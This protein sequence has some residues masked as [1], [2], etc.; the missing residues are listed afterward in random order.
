M[1][2]KISI[3]L[4]IALVLSF[5]LSNTS[6]AA[7]TVLSS[8]GLSV[9]G[10]TVN[11]EKYNVDGSNYF[12]LRDIAYLLNGTK[13][14]FAVGWDASSQT[15]SILTGE[16]YT[17]NGTELDLSGGDKSAT[18][19]PSRQTIRIDGKD[20]SGLSVYNIGGNNYF[21]LRDLGDALGFTIGYDADT[22]TATISS[23]ENKISMTAQEEAH[24]LLR[25]WINANANGRESIVG[26]STYEKSFSLDNGEKATIQLYVDD[27]TNAIRAAYYY[28]FSDGSGDVCELILLPNFTKSVV[29]YVYI[30][31]KNQNDTDTGNGIIDNTTFKKTDIISLDEFGEKFISKNN[32]GKM[33]A[34]SV[35]CILELLDGIFKQDALYFK[36]Y[37]IS[38]YGFQSLDAISQNTSTSSKE[39]RQAEAFSLLKKWIVNKTNCKV[40]GFLAYEIIVSENS[41]LR[42]VY[43]SE[44]ERVSI[45]HRFIFDNGNDAISSLSLKPN[46]EEY[47][48]ITY[49]L[50]TSMYDSTSVA[51][52]AGSINPK[53]FVGETPIEFSKYEGDENA[54]TFAKNDAALSIE[55]SLY[56]LNSLFA[57]NASYFGTHDAGS[58]G[59]AQYTR[60]S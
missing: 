38:V 31:G 6:I 54:K 10:K 45:M 48:K 42:F 16:K 20:V 52:G 27:K 40:S 59:F 60:Q 7:F 46:V 22:R 18:A 29:N 26:T 11:C 36:N 21:K 55:S 32:A 3:I 25:G 34:D 4:V 9:D 33:A 5:V 39:A 13:V 24:A 8:Q 35:C 17:A 30:S 28:H 49:S 58:F 57:Q 23:G 15:I 14:Q 12:K 1:K 37:D 41:T 44:R 43:D 2:R 56:V 51:W 50:Y 19:K 53:T 47:S